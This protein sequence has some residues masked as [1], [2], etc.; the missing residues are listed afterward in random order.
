MFERG[1]VCLDVL[2]GEAG[3]RRQTTRH[4]V[5]A[6]VG[7]GVGLSMRVGFRVRAI[8]RLRLRSGDSDSPA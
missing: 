1:A 4:L 8:V 5:R 3:E 6:S 2:R 7:V